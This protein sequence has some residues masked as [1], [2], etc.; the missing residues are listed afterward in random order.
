MYTTINPKKKTGLL[1][2]GLLGSIQNLV[3][4][5]ASRKPSA[6]GIHIKPL[7]TIKGPSVAKV[8]KEVEQKYPLVGSSLVNVFFP[9][10]LRAKGDDLLFWQNALQ[11]RTQTNQYGTRIDM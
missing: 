6:L 1:G 8:L 9:G 11:A 7:E 10:T 5:G 3:A 2:I 4:A